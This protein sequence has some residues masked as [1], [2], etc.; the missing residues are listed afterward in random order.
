MKAFLAALVAVVVVAIVA[1]IV[2]DASKE[3]TRDAFQSTGSVRL[4]G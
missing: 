4:N 2:L 1:G 3:S